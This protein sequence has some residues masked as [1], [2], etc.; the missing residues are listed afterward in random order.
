MKCKTIRG[1]V[2]DMGKLLA[3]NANKRALGNLN[4]SARGDK[5]DRNG[6]IVKTYEDIVKEYHALNPNAVKKVSL[7]N[8]ADEVF[9]TPA[10]A[11]AEAKKVKEASLKKKIIDT[12]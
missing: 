3:E 2:V 8:M 7:R 6:N 12:D 4:M 11:L 1:S 9:Q 10:D 5:L